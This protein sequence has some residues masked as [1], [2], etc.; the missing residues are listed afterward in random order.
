MIIAYYLLFMH[1]W[2]A[3]DHKINNQSFYYKE[4]I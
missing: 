3:E 4:Y 2:L 1:T